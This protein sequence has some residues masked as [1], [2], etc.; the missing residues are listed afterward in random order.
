M[1][2]E[3]ITIYQEISG[4]MDEGGGMPEDKGREPVG[5]GE[6]LCVGTGAAYWVCPFSSLWLPSIRPAVLLSSP[7][8]SAQS[9]SPSPHFGSMSVQENED[10]GPRQFWSC[11]SKSQR[12]FAKSILI[13][14]PGGK[15]IH[16]SL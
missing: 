11:I 13:G 8:L 4:N 14:A 5:L 12:D 1:A 3:W 2:S 7:P 16:R 6:G 9:R 15:R 10:T